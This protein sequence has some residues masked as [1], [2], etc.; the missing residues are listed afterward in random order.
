MKFKKILFNVIVYSMLAYTVFAG[1]HSVLPTEYQI[2]GFS[3]ISALL[4]GGGTGLL[5]TAGIYI[6]SLLAKSGVETD[7]KIA[8][9]MTGFVDLTFSV[10]KLSEEVKDLQAATIKATNEQVE[11]LERSVKLLE[12]DLQAKL[13]NAL[14]SK[15]VKERIQKAINNEEEVLD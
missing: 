5:G 1:V 12:T 8:K 13:S 2:E 4:S 11:K 10:K 6:K 15:E 14:I 7:D 3:N 9:V